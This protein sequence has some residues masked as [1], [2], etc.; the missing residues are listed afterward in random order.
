[1]SEDHPWGRDG[2]L[3]HLKTLAK[4]FGYPT[5][6]LGH[7]PAA[8]THKSYVNESIETLPNNE[9]LEFLGDAVVDLVVAEALMSAHPDAPEGV[10][11]RVRAGL[12]CSRLSLIH[13]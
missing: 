5:D 1:M 12:V 2:N 7:L 9:R 11:S 13:I 6:S 4:D 8:V 3:A 10:L